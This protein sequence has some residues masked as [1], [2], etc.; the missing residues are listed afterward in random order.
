[1]IPKGVT[2]FLCECGSTAVPVLRKKRVS[3]VIANEE[4]EITVA[5][6]ISKGRTCGVANIGYSEGRVTTFLFKFEICRKAAMAADRPGGVDDERS[7]G[8][9]GAGLPWFCKGEDGWNASGIVDAAAIEGECCRGELIKICCVVAVLNGVLEGEG[10]AAR[11]GAV[12]DV[13]IPAAGFELESR[14][15]GGGVNIDRP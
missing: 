15:A 14:G 8:C 3:P 9:Q 10:G 1:M 5:I 11:A 13:A 12:N 4:I 7:I 2:T 6:D